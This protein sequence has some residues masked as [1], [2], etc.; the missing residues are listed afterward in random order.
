[1]NPKE[2]T[3]IEAPDK[4]KVVAKM[5]YKEII[6][7]KMIEMRNNRGRRPSGRGTR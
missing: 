2:K 3:Q 6:T 4:G 1:M 7:G 5:E